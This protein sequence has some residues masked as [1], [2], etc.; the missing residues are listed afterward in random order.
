[1]KNV[2]KKI[3]VLFCLL[4]AMCSLTACF[5]GGGGS[6]GGGGEKTTYK[7]EFV[8]NGGSEIAA[9]DIEKGES[10]KIITD[11][12]KVNF[13][14]AA[15]YDNESF[16]GNQ[17]LFPFTPSADTKLYAKWGKQASVIDG[18]R[19][20][21]VRGDNGDSGVTYSISANSVTGEDIVIPYRYNNRPVT[22]I[23]YFR[24][25][26]VF[27]LTIH[28]GIEVCRST[29][30]G[31]FMVKFESGKTPNDFDN[32][33]SKVIMNY[34]TN[35]KD[36]NGFK[37][38]N[39]GGVYYALKDGE[40][41]VV[42]S[43]ESIKEATV[44]S[45][46]TQGETYNITTI[47]KESFK[48]RSELTKISIS[49]GITEIGDWAFSGARISVIDFP[50]SLKKIGLRA[51]SDCVELTSVSLKNVTSIGDNAFSY[52]DKLIGVDLG[53]VTSIGAR[54]FQSCKLERITI[55]SLVTFIGADVFYGY[56]TILYC[57]A[58]SK[59]DG[60]MEK[61]DN[62]STSANRIVVWDCLNNDVAQDGYIYATIDELKYKILDSKATLLGGKPK[63]EFVIPKTITF[64]NNEYKVTQIDEYAFENNKEIT[65]VVVSSNILAI[66]EG[67]FWGCPNLTN[68]FIPYEV[69]SIGELAF[70]LTSPSAIIN[71]EALSSDKWGEDWYSSDIPPVYGYGIKTSE[72]GF[73]YY[74]KIW[75]DSLGEQPVAL[76]L[77]YIGDKSEVSVPNN[78]DEYA[79]VL[80]GTFKNNKV[81][82]KVTLGKYISIIGD[83]TFNKC[84]KLV[85]VTGTDNITIIG[86]N[87][88]ENCFQ[89]TSFT[90]SSKIKSIGESAFFQC[91]RLESSVTLSEG[92]TSLGDAA[93]VG[94]KIADITLPGT[95]TYFGV[96]VLFNCANLASITLSSENSVIDSDGSAI[97]TKGFET[98][99]MYPTLK[100]SAEYTIHQNTKK[101]D[102]SAFYSNLYLKKINLD[103]GKLETIGKN[104]FASSHLESVTIP[105]SVKK[106]ENFAFE[107]NSFLNSVI[108]ISGDIELEE[109][110]FS[111]C[112]NLKDVTLTLGLKT[113]PKNTFSSCKNLESIVIP[114]GVTE[115]GEGAFGGC[116]NL[117][118]VILSEGLEQIGNFAFKNC[119]KLI[120]ITL[121]DSLITIADEAFYGSGLKSLHIPKNVK[122]IWT[123]NSGSLES[124]TVD[125]EN[126][127]FSSEDGILYSGSTL[128]CYPSKKTSG[129]VTVKDGVTRIRVE[130]FDFSVTETLIL[131]V[132]LT[133]IGEYT[134]NVNRNLVNVIMNCKNIDDNI[135][136]NIA[137]ETYCQNLYISET[138]DVTAKEF[139]KSFT[140]A[141][142][143][144]KEGY[145]KYIK[146]PKVTA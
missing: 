32:I 83:K 98:L 104:A 100:T 121:P 50:K 88:F 144:D 7:L 78:F 56:G 4:L 137:T 18:A 10:I 64:K 146:N 96:G 127:I 134:M 84:E 94:S 45:S 2:K 82:T 1:M 52:C 130:A 116:S 61:W 25:S 101:I 19:F 39:D 86:N 31:V 105:S 54:A 69:L 129:T 66:G 135:I 75:E 48:R 26:N 59:P 13:S 22:V 21:E 142:T 81:I 112:Q 51:F 46:I 109:S 27:S 95:L 119:S 38:Y 113:I 42:G 40:G 108:F 55:S 17:I 87:A 133:E 111:Y 102:N 16:M 89:L 125:A 67:A 115:I 3:V 110:I 71:C 36:S 41:Q 35:D 70:L 11:P 5:G 122:N 34:L 118:S 126:P 72:D 23:E 138:S 15:W 9:K 90:F 106:I 131:P 77:N 124:V 20:M 143:S 28:S 37:Y 29:T 140:K 76:V 44:K 6:G 79:V 114:K 53:K 128:V 63:S 80:E 68:V 123:I 62:I 14:F 85:S 58:S 92:F 60:F 132:S 33:G 91:A 120:S 49:E 136:K 12:T 74:E 139:L 93:F 43:D 57:E 141:E 103:N 117:S 107:L 97:Y 47:A 24:C 145:I 8:T 99:I 65:S 73:Q 30:Q